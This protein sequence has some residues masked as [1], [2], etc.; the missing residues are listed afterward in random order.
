MSSYSRHT[1]NMQELAMQAPMRWG[2]RVNKTRPDMPLP[3]P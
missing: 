1:C 3:L 2:R